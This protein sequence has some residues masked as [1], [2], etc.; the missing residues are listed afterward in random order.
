AE[1]ILDRN[2]GDGLG[3]V[4]HGVVDHGEP[5]VSH[6]LG[7]VGEADSLRYA[8]VGDGI[9]AGRALFRRAVV[10][11]RADIAC[12]P[13]ISAARHVGELRIDVVD[14]QGEAGEIVQRRALELLHGLA[15]VVDHQ[16]VLHGRLLDVVL[17]RDGHHGA[18]DHPR[19]AQARLLHRV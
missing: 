4:G 9:E 18:R 2:D 12:G 7:Y 1:Q 6:G 5:R 13:R 11:E 3:V 14:A 19:L 17:G 15:W 8:A 16:R 10:A